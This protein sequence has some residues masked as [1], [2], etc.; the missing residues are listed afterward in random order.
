[1]TPPLT[2]AA[3]SSTYLVLINQRND[4]ITHGR[5]RQRKATPP[6]MA[7]AGSSTDLVL[8]NQRPWNL[9]PPLS[10][11]T[12]L[13]VGSMAI[14]TIV[15]IRAFLFRAFFSIY[16]RQCVEDHNSVFPVI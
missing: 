5:R 6:L 14:I 15:L 11:S 12:T 8:I 9:S 10:P 16:V 4:T 13:V 3:R 7:A 1:M 2:A